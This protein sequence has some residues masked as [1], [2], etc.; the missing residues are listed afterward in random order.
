M[1]SFSFSKFYKLYGLFHP[2][3]RMTLKKCHYFF[4]GDTNISLKINIYSKQP[5]CIY[6][7]RFGR[8]PHD[9]FLQADQIKYLTYVY[10]NRSLTEKEN[11]PI[12]EWFPPLG[13]F[14]STVRP[15]FHKI[16]ILMV[17]S[18]LVFINEGSAE[19]LMILVQDFYLLN[20]S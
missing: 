4:L 13:Q 1:S 16:W 8:G 12:R 3:R 9:L 6:Q 18:Q 19:V 10:W 17:Y 2:G 20:L 14:F 5:T 7:L 11:C 15:I